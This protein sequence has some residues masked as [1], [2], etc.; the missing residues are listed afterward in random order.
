M[1]SKLIMESGFNV[2]GKAW[3]SYLYTHT[4]HTHPYLIP[5]LIRKIYTN[6]TNNVNYLLN[7]EVCTH[8]LGPFLPLLLY[9]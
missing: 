8:M 6:K 4:A 9:F 1:V 7:M 3:P 2:L 5:D